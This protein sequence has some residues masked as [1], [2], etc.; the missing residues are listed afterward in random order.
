MSLLFADRHLVQ[1]VPFRFLSLLFVFSSHLQIASAQLPQTRLNSLSPSGGTIGQEF[2]VRVASGTDLEEID[3][4]I[5]SD[6]RI[7]TRQKMTGEMGRESPVPNTFIVTIPEDIPAGTVEARVGG[8]WGFSN[9]R[10]FAIDFDP[11]VLEKEGNNAPEAAATIPMNCVVDGRLDGANDVD[12][13][14]FQGSA[15]QRVILSCATA[16]IDSQTEPVLAVYDA[17]GRHRLKWKQASGSGD[18]TFA[19]DVPAD[20]EYL[21]RLH[22]ITF[23][24]GPN[25]YYRLHI[26]D[27]PQIEFALPPYLTAGSTAP[28]QIF[29][30]NLSGSQLTDQMVDGSRLES[31]TVDVSAPEHALQLSVENR[32]APLA[33]GTDGFTYRF[34]SNDRVSNPITF[35]LTPLPATL[36][37]EPNQ[38]GTSAQLVNAPVVIGGQFSAPGDSDAFRFSAKAGDVW[39]LEAISERL[40]TLGDPLLI[41]NRITSNPDG[42]ESVQ[43]ITAQDDTGTNLLANTFETQSD[44]PVFRLEV[45]ED[46]LYEAVVRDRYWETRG[47][48][49]LRYALSIR[50]Q[51]PDVRVIAVPDAPTAGQTW[52]VSLRK[53]DQFP[54]SLLLFRSDGFNDPVEVFATNLPEGLSCR[55]VTIGQGQ[56]S[57][58]IVIEANENTAS[59]LHPLTLSYRTTIDDPNLWKVLESARTAHQESAKLVAESQAKLDALNAQ[60]SATNQQ[61][62][63]AEAANAEQPQAESPSE[64]IAKLRS[65]VD[66]LTQQLSAATQELEAAKATLASNAE[67]VAEAEAAFHSARRNIE[68][69]V[70]VGTIVWSSAA[71]VPAISRLT[72]ALNVSVMDEPA[73]FQLTTDVHRI[74][75]NQSRQVLLPIHLA[76][77]M[78]FDEKVTLT[79]QGLPKSANIDFPNAEIPKG[80][81]SATM[82][83]FVKEN[84]PPGHYVAW[85]KSQGQVSYRRNPQKADRLKQAFEQATAA[86]QA[87]KQRESEAAAA[88]EQSVATLEAAKKTLADLTSS[89]QSIAAALQ[90]QTATHQQKSLSTNQAQLTAAEDEVALRKAQGELL[91]LEA[92]IQEQTPESKQKINE[93]RERVAAAD[94]KF[95]A[96]LAESQKA[97][98]E[99]GAITEQLNQTRAQSKTIDNSIQK[100][101]ADLKAAETALQVADKNLSEATAAAASSEKT[102][103]DAEKR[104]ADA[105]KASKA[106]NINFTPPSTPI[107]IEVLTGPVKLSA[108]ANNG[109]KLKPGE[110]L[111]IPV[112]VTRRNGF[113]GPLTLT[114]FPTTDQSPLAC[115][116]VEIPADQTTATLTVRATESAS[117]GKVSNVVVR[118]TMEFS[119]T[120]EVDEP[121]EIEIVN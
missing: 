60:L 114:I 70:R 52:P 61:L 66:S 101:T 47:N 3:T 10:R 116:P 34:T 119:G 90:E 94:A 77:R 54:V 72:S 51:Y 16:S 65:E 108:K 22:D 89:Q 48:P 68:A 83:I 40:Q 115:D 36:E 27:G 37:T 2:E 42:T 32:I 96:S 88:K 19:F 20:G 98:E 41:V 120:A 117:A 30:Y 110:S 45:G 111:E 76:K 57:G 12:W 31:V 73:P 86:A 74:T 112:T 55:D 59:G 1:R 97:T 106:A 85:L 33:S 69:P 13:F 56:T 15:L 43:R 5:F 4:L 87:A 49:R 121:V 25:F 78:S 6:L 38:E 102:R 7:Q 11:T 75:V 29:G 63:E 105:E 53:G 18:C 82:R 95:R 71:N 107:V 118:A 62:T 58:T 8:L 35:G 26:H 23:R 113:A 21:L 44:D 81:D 104:S 99:L 91:K 93:L 46:G 14:R 103:K 92:E 17:T 50:K 64:Q 100:A 109:G 9:P 24:N 80:A 84:T 67:R 28:V 39:Y 79:P